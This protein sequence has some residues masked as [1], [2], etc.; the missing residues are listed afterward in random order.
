M[1]Q[2]L[3]SWSCF[4]IGQGLRSI[5]GLE[6]ARTAFA[7]LTLCLATAVALASLSPAIVQADD[8]DEVASGAVSR[9][10]SGNDGAPG[11]IGTS[12]TGGSVGTAGAG[13]AAG[14]GN[15]GGTSEATRTEATSID[16]STATSVSPF[17]GFSTSGTSAQPSAS[18]HATGA[19]ASLMSPSESVARINS[20]LAGKG[21]SGSRSGTK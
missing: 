13:G 12:S 14:S 9:S 10:S 21:D 8:G 6:C 3:L 1:K 20:L 5:G 2:F 4:G 17:A 7:A 16:C 18:C 11:S 19:P 15:G